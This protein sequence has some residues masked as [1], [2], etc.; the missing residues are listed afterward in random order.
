M[1]MISKTLIRKW[2]SKK[3][4]KKVERMASQLERVRVRLPASNLLEEFEFLDYVETV[5]KT[6]NSKKDLRTIILEAWLLIDYVATRV[7]LDG[8]RIPESIDKALKLLPYSFEAK[9]NLIKK[10]RK[11]EQDKLPNRESYRA[12]ELHPKFYMKLSREEQLYKQFLDLAMQFEAE[13][14]PEGTPYYHPDF[15]ESRFVPEW[16]IKQA[17]L[18]DDKWFWH[19][20][21]LNKTRNIVVHQRRINVKEIYNDFGVTS[22]K[23][24]KTTLKEMIE[25]II[26]KN[27]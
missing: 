27:S 7:L 22:L 9:M 8:L 26:F 20:E 15:E 16:W 14:T 5:T 19:C 25:L 21:Q 12:F 18:L 23:D 24:L 2:L 11:V 6:I 10:L 4:T 1:P 3:K 17:K 13:S